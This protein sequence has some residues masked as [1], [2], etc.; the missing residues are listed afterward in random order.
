M[1][2][3]ST[4]RYWTSFYPSNAAPIVPADSALSRWKR[5]PAPNRPLPSSIK[6]NWTVAPFASTNR[7]PRA[8]V[9]PVAVAE[10][11]WAP[12]GPVDSIPAANPKSNSTWEISVLTRKRKW[13]VKSLNS[14]DKSRM[15]LCRRIAIRANPAAF[16]LSPC[17][18]RRPRRRAKNSM[19]TKW[20]DDPCA[21][22]KRN[23]RAAAAAVVVVEITEVATVVVAEATAAVA[24]DTVEATMIVEAMAAE[25]VDTAA[26]RVEAADTEE[27]TMTEVAMVAL[28]EEEAMDL[29][30][31]AVATAAGTMTEV[32]L[33][34][35]VVV[36][37]N[38]LNHCHMMKF[39][40]ECFRYGGGY[41]D[42]GYGG[43]GGGGGGYGDRY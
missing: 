9:R 19:V 8:A 6:S 31:E 42:R 36:S 2:F 37:G 30:V 20:T 3:N 13:S 32:D 34:E 33:A 41:D 7:V 28:R 38:E 23:P 26:A 24:V 22:T 4:A 18:R 12:A 15:P 35:V 5:G 17:R 10:K 16:V 11:A 29:V 14:T 1:N 21:S 39:P 25:E 27:V 40:W 43:G